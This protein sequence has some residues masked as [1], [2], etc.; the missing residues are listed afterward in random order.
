MLKTLLS[1]CCI[2]KLTEH[3]CTFFIAHA[4]LLYYVIIPFYLI[5]HCPSCILTTE[6]HN[7][8]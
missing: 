8:D 1:G 7:K 5:A 6:F 2:K 4:R 3:I